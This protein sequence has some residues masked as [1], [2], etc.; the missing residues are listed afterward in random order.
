MLSRMF[1]GIISH[2]VEFYINKLPSEKH[3]L[4]ESFKLL[5][6]DET[7]KNW[8][9]KNVITNLKVNAGGFQQHLSSLIYFY[10]S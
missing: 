3:D 7:F 1:Y 10:A 8:Q 4:L 9:H 5:L 2:K 6:F